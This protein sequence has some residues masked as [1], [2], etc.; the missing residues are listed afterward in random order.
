MLAGENIDTPLPAASMTKLMTEYI[1]LKEV[2]EGRLHWDDEIIITEHTAHSEGVK[3][4]VEPETKVSVRDLYS[5]IVIGSANNAAVALA[6]KIG[7]SS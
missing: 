7:G 1:V 4:E 5:S 3:I 2:Y 6:E